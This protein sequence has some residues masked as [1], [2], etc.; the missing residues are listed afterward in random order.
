M[1]DALHELDE[2]HDHDRGLALDLSTSS[3]GAVR[4]S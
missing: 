1:A 3:S 4:S 2:P